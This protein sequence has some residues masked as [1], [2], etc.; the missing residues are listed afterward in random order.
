MNLTDT[1]PCLVGFNLQ[2]D[3]PPHTNTKQQQQTN[4]TKNAGIYH[5]ELMIQEIRGWY[6]SHQ[7][8]VKLNTHPFRG[9]TCIWILPFVRTYIRCSSFPSRPGPEVINLSALSNS[10]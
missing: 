5:P 2:K 8:T 10:K 6:L 4:T 3:P 9:G 7:R 1:C